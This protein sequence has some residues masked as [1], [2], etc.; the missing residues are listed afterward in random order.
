MEQLFLTNLTFYFYISTFKSITYDL[1]YILLLYIPVVF[2]IIV[3][4][5]YLLSE[6]LV[7]H[8]LL[9]KISHSEYEPTMS[10]KLQK[11]IKKINI[12]QNKYETNSDPRS[13]EF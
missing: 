5:L 4:I 10:Q 7:I 6:Y 2:V 1:F 13:Y 3:I 8:F 12:S 9:L 11:Q